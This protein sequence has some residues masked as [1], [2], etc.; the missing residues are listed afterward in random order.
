MITRRIL[1]ELIGAIDSNP[2]VAL[3]GPRQV[4]K[5]TLALE[6]GNTRPSLYLDLESASNRQNSQTPSVISESM[7]TYW[8]SWTRYTGHRNCFRVSAG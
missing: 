3:L 2:A 1:A 6:I 7:R 8:S 4:G 5:T